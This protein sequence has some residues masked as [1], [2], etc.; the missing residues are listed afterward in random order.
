LLRP[1]RNGEKSD[2]AIAELQRLLE[3]P[4]LHG[5]VL[6]MTAELAEKW[7]AHSLAPALV[8]AAESLAP[9]PE[10]HKRDPGCEGKQAVLHALATWEADVPA[11]YHAAARWIQREPVQRGTIDTAAECRGLAAIGIA[12]TSF[13]KSESLLVIIDLLADTEATTRLRAA[14][15]LAI[16]RGTETVP[17]LRM[18]ALAGDASADVLGETLVGLLRHDPR[19]HVD[20]VAKFLDNEEPAIVEVAALALGESHQPA[21]LQPLTAAWDRLDRQPIATTLLMAIALLRT[22]ESVAW[23]LEKLEKERLSIVQQLLHA[24]R[25]Y[26]G[27]ARIAQRVKDILKERDEEFVEAYRDVFER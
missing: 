27:D 15:A 24:L 19:G 12:Q 2:A 16:W 1:L 13:G 4:R 3:S 7:D 10:I 22:E 11:F 5:M 14:Q 17:L 8:I 18:K 25:I 21:A 23:L 20:F 9:A 26:K 6:K